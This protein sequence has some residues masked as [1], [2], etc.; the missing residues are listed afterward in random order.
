MAKKPIHKNIEKKDDSESKLFAL[1]GILLT[2]VGYIIV[3]L[4]RKDDKY[5]MYYA[6]QGLIL[7]IACVIAWAASGVLGWIP[8][9]GEALG[10]VVN[11]IMLVLWIIGIVYSL[12]GEE[13]EVPI[14]GPFARKL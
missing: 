3:V 11:A 12:S 10:W 8:F 13:K 9:I 2:I 7:F 5:A 6:K 4:A 1:L 14:I